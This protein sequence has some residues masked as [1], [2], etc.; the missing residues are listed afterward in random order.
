MVAD[1]EKDT[2][3]FKM[4][5]RFNAETPHK[6]VAMLK[7]LPK[8]DWERV[9][10]DMSD[11]VFMDS[12]GIGVLVFLY[13]ELTS[14]GK[15]LVLRKPQRK[16]Y[17]LLTEIGIDRLFDVELASG[18]KKGEVRLTE[19]DNQLQIDEEVINDIYIISLAGVM[20]YPTG[21]TLFKNRMFLTLAYTKKILLDCK[22]LAFFDSLSVGSVLRL[23]RLLQDNGGCM[24][25]CCANNVVRDVFAS[26]GI[27]S[28]IRVYGTREAA[29][30]DWR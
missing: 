28:I 15:A 3:T 19:L 16:I 6:T 30:A 17:E 11:N 21:S 1:S 2:C 7:E 5:E 4:P 26:L 29:L 10:L 14:K 23:S 25:V 24:K 27:D 8:G 12:A 13:K 9:V 18:V 22:G 20:N